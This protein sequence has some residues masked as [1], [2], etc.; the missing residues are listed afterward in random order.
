MFQKFDSDLVLSRLHPEDQIQHLQALTIGYEF[1]FGLP[2]AARMQ[3]IFSN[4]LRYLTRQGRYT[5]L[6]Q[7]N[8]ILQHDSEGN[9]THT[10]FTLST[11]DHLNLQ[12]PLSAAVL[13]QHGALY[14]T[15]DF[16]TGTFQ[17]RQPLTPRQQQ[18]LKLVG[19]GLSSK[20]IAQ[21]LDIKL[22]T[23]HS[24]RRDM[25]TKTG[26]RNTGELMR[27]AMAMGLL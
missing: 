9:M 8:R 1:L 20:E 19:Q 12:G 18:I 11:L 25:L 23:V 21:A 3:Y 2:P 4:D 13:D 22:H 27:L 14:Q 15:L 6:L 16:T 10:L 5:R 7:Q 17:Q 24:H 26:C